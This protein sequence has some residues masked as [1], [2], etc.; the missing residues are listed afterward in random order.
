M[1]RLDTYTQLIHYLATNRHTNRT[2]QT[3]IARQ[4]G[5]ATATLS[6]WENEY[7]T[8]PGDHLIELIH[9]NGIDIWLDKRPLGNMK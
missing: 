4:L 3:A 6:N 9:A 7:R 1:I 8:V 2:P 5:I